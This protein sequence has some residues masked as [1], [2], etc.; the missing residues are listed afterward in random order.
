MF[1][2]QTAMKRHPLTFSIS[3]CVNFYFVDALLCVLTLLPRAACRALLLVAA[4][5]RSRRALLAICVIIRTLLLLCY[6][7]LLVL[8][9][10][11]SLLR[12][13]APMCA[14]AY[15]CLQML[16][17]VHDAAAYRDLLTICVAYRSRYYFCVICR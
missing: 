2:M 13:G 11:S 1:V 6:Y 5:S 3:Y 12:V 17:C 7:L 15:I 4:C 8:C 10:L 14:P 16:C 9:V